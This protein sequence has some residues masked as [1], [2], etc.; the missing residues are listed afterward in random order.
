MVHAVIAYMAAGNLHDLE[1]APKFRKVSE[2][3][4]I[5]VCIASSIDF[6]DDPTISVTL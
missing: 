1:P 2:A 5:A 3:R 4:E 6:S